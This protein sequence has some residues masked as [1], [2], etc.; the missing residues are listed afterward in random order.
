MSELMR[1]AFLDKWQSF[2]FELEG[3]DWSHCFH[4]LQPF[5][6]HVLFLVRV[7]SLSAE[8]LLILPYHY[9]RNV[10]L[11]VLLVYGRSF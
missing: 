9:D 10:L 7:L 2:L 3:S 6:R 11:D 4:S 1:N 8:V 5:L